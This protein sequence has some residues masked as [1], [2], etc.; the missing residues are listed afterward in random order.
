MKDRKMSLKKKYL[1]GFRHKKMKLSP[2]IP[3]IKN[4]WKSQVK[5]VNSDSIPRYQDPK[6]QILDILPLRNPFWNENFEVW[7]QALW[8][9]LPILGNNLGLDLELNNLL[10]STNLTCDLWP[11]TMTM[12]QVVNHTKYF[13]STTALLL[14]LHSAT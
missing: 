2:G 13:S 3:I 12:N 10:W 8:H 14:S 1:K 5:V 6:F 11:A 7:F 4:I 9:F